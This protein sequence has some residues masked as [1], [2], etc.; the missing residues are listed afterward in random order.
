MTQTICDLCADRP[1]FDEYRRLV[2]V[3][4]CGRCAEAVANAHHMAHSGEWLTWPNEPTTRRGF[5]KAVIPHAIRRAVYERD[6]YRCVECDTHIDLTLDH[7]KPE[8]KGG[9]TTEANLRTLCR[10][11]NSRKGARE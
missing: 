11:C 3:S 7:I 2:G 9:E 10:P 1:A 6:K 5:Q 4:V 8:S